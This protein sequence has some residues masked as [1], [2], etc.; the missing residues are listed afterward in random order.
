MMSVGLTGCIRQLRAVA[1]GL[2]S[3]MLRDAGFAVFLDGHV[4]FGVEFQKL[5]VVVCDV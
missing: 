5:D 3:M 4:A 1:W 2:A